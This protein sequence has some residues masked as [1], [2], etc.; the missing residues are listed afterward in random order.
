MRT[1]DVTKKTLEELFNAQMVKELIYTGG[2]LKFIAGP[3][4]AHINPI[5][6]LLPRL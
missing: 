4:L 2:T 6:N 1:T 3:V 5:Q